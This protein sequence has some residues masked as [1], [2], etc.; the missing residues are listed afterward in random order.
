MLEELGYDNVEVRVGDGTAAR[1]TGRRSTPSRSRRPPDEP[2]AALLDQLAPG[3]PLVC[4]VERRRARAPLRFRDGREE[5]IVPVRF[6]PLVR[7]AR[8]EARVLRRR[9]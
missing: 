1:P 6:V 3:A 5:T 8:R 7:E 2:P 9:A 4:P